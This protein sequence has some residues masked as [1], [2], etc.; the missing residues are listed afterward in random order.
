MSLSVR[1]QRYCL[2]QCFCCSVHSPFCQGAQFDRRTQQC[3]YCHQ[4]ASVCAR[5]RCLST[6]LCQNIDL[7]L[8]TGESCSVSFGVT[9]MRHHIIMFPQTVIS[10]V[11]V[12]IS[13]CFDCPQSQC[14]CRFQWLISF[15][16]FCV[17][18]PRTCGIFCQHPM[19]MLSRITIC[20][21]ISRMLSTVFPQSA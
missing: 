9:L 19:L 20:P 15:S 7:H 16:H 14:N 4:T 17:Y 8:R 5:Y 12:L 2:Y 18:A 21:V 1:V 3:S 13:R 11:I 6:T 10:F